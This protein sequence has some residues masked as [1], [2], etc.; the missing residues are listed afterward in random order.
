MRRCAQSVRQKALKVPS[1]AGA[2][3]LRAVIEEGLERLNTLTDVCYKIY[4]NLALFV[5]AVVIK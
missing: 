4:F 5:R 2:T 3:A 1:H